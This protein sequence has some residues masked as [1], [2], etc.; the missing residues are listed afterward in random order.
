MKITLLSFGFK[1]GMP[2]DADLVVDMRFLSNP[3]FVPELK[4]LN[5]LTK[6]VRDFV[7]ETVQAR[8]FLKKYLNLLD[9]LIPLY[10]LEGKAYLTIAVG[11]TGG[12]HRSVAIAENIFEHLSQ[13]GFEP[14]IIHRDL[15]RDIKES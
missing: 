12:R 4:A 11:C 8:T 14:G 13:R 15:D 3:F 9:Y 10:T 6:E 5:G 7:L 1:Y 2:T